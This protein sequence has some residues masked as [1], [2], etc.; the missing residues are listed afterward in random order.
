MH[1]RHPSIDFAIKIER[2]LTIRHQD[3]NNIGTSFYDGFGFTFIHPPPSLD[4]HALATPSIDFAIGDTLTIR[5]VVD[6]KYDNKN[7]NKDATRTR[8][9][10]M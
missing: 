8:T 10:E 6:F 4:L 2:H 1:Q 9:G 5:G 7:Y 3:Q